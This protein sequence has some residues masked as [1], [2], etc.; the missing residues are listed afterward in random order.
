MAG[1]APTHFKDLQSQDHFFFKQRVWGHLGWRFH[2]PAACPKLWKFPEV[3][4]SHIWA[5]NTISI[6]LFDQFSH[7]S[8]WVPI[9]QY[10][11]CDLH[12]KRNPE[13]GGLFFH[14]YTRNLCRTIMSWSL[15]YT[16]V[17]WRMK[18]CSCSVCLAR[19]S[20]GLRI[21][22]YCH[23]PILYICYQC[24]DRAIVLRQ[25]HHI[26]GRTREN[27]CTK[28]PNIQRLLLQVRRVW[29][30]VWMS[31]DMHVWF[32]RLNVEGFTITLQA[33]ICQV[34]GQQP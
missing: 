15:Q 26:F 21:Y 28:V 2:V 6:G 12:T 14:S 3:R 10:G 11:S 8:V 7:K 13:T 30:I 32:V 27:K 23:E 22:V 5:K 31:W 34:D 16:E 1:I 20:W 24:K 9:C 17:A 19:K 4:T 18:P 33:S 25:D 29:R